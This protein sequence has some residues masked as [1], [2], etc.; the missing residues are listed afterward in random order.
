MGEI[1]EVEV[2]M[3]VWKRVDWARE[4]ALSVAQSKEGWQAE[5][6]IDDIRICSSGYAEPGYTDPACGLIATGNWNEVDRYDRD[7]KQRVKIDNTASRLASIFEKLGVEIE[8]SDE[9]TECN[10]CNRL[11]RLSPDSYGW[12]PSFY[13]SDDGICCHDCI[14]PE[15]YL[16]GLE[17]QERQCNTIIDDP[18][19]HGYQYVE[20]FE[21]GMYGGQDASPSLIF[22]TM[23]EAGFSRFIFH[24]ESQGQ[25]D[26]HF[27]LY[28]HDEETTWGGLD[29]AKIA[30]GEG[31]T[32]G[33]S[34]VDALKRG[35]EA[36]R[37]QEKELRSEGS[38]GDGIVV[39]QIGPEGATTKVISAQDFID[40]KAFDGP[41]DES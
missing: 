18:S 7:T 36:S 32:D 20:S 35:L 40:G 10:E 12:T 8:W 3:A 19:D 38:V 2:D 17:G 5:S 1:Q 41:E 27:A 25:F 31:R 4:A 24:I 23:R 16:E 34:V 26:T 39:S 33:P 6:S 11:L 37:Q 22:K 13:A 14:V 30:V 9:W 21:H 28:L 15:D 29:R